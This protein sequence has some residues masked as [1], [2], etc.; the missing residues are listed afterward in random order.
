M[1][2]T[3]IPNGFVFMGPNDKPMLVEFDD[4]GNAADDGLEIEIG[5]WLNK[6]H[7]DN[8]L[9]GD[10]MVLVHFVEGESQI[11]IKSLEVERLLREGKRI[12]AMDVAKNGILRDL[13]KALR[14][15]YI[16]EKE[17]EE[18]KEEKT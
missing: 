1:K 9:P 15:K 8:D 10:A 13:A 12:S 5:S 6:L 11:L 16:R 18:K 17:V 7:E 4:N 3:D 2:S 14:E